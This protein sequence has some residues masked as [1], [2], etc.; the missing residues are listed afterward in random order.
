M[1]S[2]S[3]GGTGDCAAASEGRLRKLRPDGEVKRCLAARVRSRLDRFMGA[4]SMIRWMQRVRGTRLA[5]RALLHRMPFTTSP[6][7]VKSSHDRLAVR[8]V[9]LLPFA[10]QPGPAL[11]GCESPG[12]EAGKRQALL[13]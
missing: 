4:L 10:C 5:A 2:P 11:A 6:N 13:T 1:P 3:L 8:Y 9:Y 7:L 12:V